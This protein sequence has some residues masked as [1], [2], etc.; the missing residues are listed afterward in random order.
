MFQ[1]R[2]KAVVLA[3]GKGERLRP[4]TDC[5]P[6]SMVRI[7]GKPVIDYVLEGLRKLPLDE[8]IIVLSHKKLAKYV[9]EKWSN[10]IPVTTIYQKGEGV[11]GA[12]LTA[13]ELLGRQMFML[14][15]GDIVISPKAYIRTLETHINSGAEASI[16]LSPKLDV[17]SYGIAYVSENK[18]LN[19]KE[20]PLPEKAEST[21]AIAGVFVLPP[22]FLDYVEEYG[23]T[24]ALNILAE[25]ITMAPCFW[26]DWW[27]DIGY[28]W[29]I[30]KANEY[31][32]KDL[33]YSQISS[34][35]VIS[36]KA[37]IEGPVIIDDDAEICHYAVIKGPVY[38][39]KGS[40]IGDHCL[41]RR[42]ASIEE[43]TIVGAFS[44]VKY[45]SIQ[46]NV[47]ISSHSYIGDSVVGENSVIGPN[48]VTLNIL[49]SGV[50]VSRLH[51]IRI[52]GKMVT[53]LGAIIGCNVYIGAN[54]VLY[55]GSVVE[56]NTRTSPHTIITHKES[57]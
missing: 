55:A 36:S 11:E 27:V 23:F 35:A 54:N 37:V 24:D 51:P 40:F 29:D 18:I 14:A 50:K 2:L 30:L 34:N 48:T 13:K 44:E 12:V 53:K 45:S 26:E 46:P 32:L 41:I 6:K 5:V 52:R 3:G 16:L 15:Y 47:T 4:L 10:I 56:S 31:V 8:V 38:I 20:K 39:G 25:K 49:P 28:P 9:E 1:Y 43:N 19:V 57:P 42:F 21:L 22:M 7:V 17:E 33:K